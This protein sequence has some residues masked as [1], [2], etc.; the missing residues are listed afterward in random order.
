MKKAY[1]EGCTLKCAAFFIIEKSSLGGR[2]KFY[3][4]AFNKNISI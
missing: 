2:K 1:E 3:K 4:I